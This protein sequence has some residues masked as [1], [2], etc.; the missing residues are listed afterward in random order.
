MLTGFGC[1]PCYSP[2]MQILRTSDYQKLPWKNGLGVSHVVASDPPSAGYDAVSWQIGTTEFGTDCPFSS[3]PGMDRQFM[4]LSGGGVELHCID[5]ISSVDVRKEVDVPFVPFAFTG[6]WTTTCRMLGA[7]VRVFNVM[8]RR[9]KA[10]ARITLPRWTGP[11]YCEQRKGETLVA[12]MLAG[13]ALIAGEAAP[14][15][16]NDAV[17]LADAEGGRCEIVASGGDARMAVVRVTPA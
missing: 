14:L 11:L 17:M 2:A 7:P 6:D 4:L 15:K 16:P 13:N 10:S 1:A 3:L 9:G 5:I 12:V 8:T